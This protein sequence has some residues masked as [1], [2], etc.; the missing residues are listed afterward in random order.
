MSTS[1]PHDRRLE[2]KQLPPLHPFRT[3]RQRLACA[4]RCP[5]ESVPINDSAEEPSVHPSRVSGR[6]EGRFKSSEIFPFMLSVSKHSWGSSAE[7]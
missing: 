6:T 1:D 4:A 3:R 5:L 7:S 2:T